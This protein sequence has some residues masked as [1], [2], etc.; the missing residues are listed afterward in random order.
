MHLEYLC[1]ANW[2]T[3]FQILETCGS[4]AEEDFQCHLEDNRKSKSRFIKGRCYRA[5]SAGGEMHPSLQSAIPPLQPPPPTGQPSAT[6]RPTAAS[7]SLSFRQLRRKFS[8]PPFHVH[9]YI[10]TNKQTNKRKTNITSHHKIRECIQKFRDWP[11]GART[12]NG[13]ALCH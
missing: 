9:T 10:Y 8:Y 5:H 6:T 2:N 11:P 4:G 1:T 13:T 7:V 12:V 3:T